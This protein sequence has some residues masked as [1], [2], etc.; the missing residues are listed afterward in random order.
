MVRGTAPRLRGYPHRSKP[1]ELRLLPGL[2]CVMKNVLQVAVASHH[3][4]KEKLRR[5]TGGSRQTI[6]DLT[7]IRPGSDRA[8][9]GLGFGRLVEANARLR[10]N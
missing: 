4:S 3:S 9:T 5:S 10:K 6:R 8:P 1:R 2:S 7:G